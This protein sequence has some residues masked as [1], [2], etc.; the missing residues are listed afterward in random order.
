MTLTTLQP[1]SIQ[2]DRLHVSYLSAGS[3]ENPPLLLIHG[4]VSANLFWDDTLRALSEEYWVLAPD[5]RGYGQTEA[6]PIDA[7]RGLRDWSD[8][9]KLFLGA[10]GMSQPVHVLGWSLGAGIAMQLA[11]D[12][13]ATVRSLVLMSPLS[14]YGF[15][16]TKDDRG[17]PCYDNYAGS[18][19][20]TANP[21]FVACLSGK[22]RSVG[23]PN[24]PRN[25]LNQFYF[26]SPFRVGGEREE[27]Y[28]DAMLSTRIGDAH[29][30]GAF[31][32]CEHWPGVAPGAEGINNAMSPKYVNLSPIIHIE[33][34]RPILWIRGADDVIVSDSSWFDFGYLGK[35]G[36]VEGWPGEEV[37]PPQPMVSQM[38]CVLKQYEEAGG[39][40]EELVV[41]DAGHAPHIEQPE[42]VFAKLRSFLEIIE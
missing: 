14:P 2:T 11:I 36:Y 39:S 17:T 38:R 22:D 41:G 13:P 7:T 26:K 15:G 6:L 1:Q 3:A 35:L 5:L 33:P 20:G 42:I 29:Y 31:E 40:F 25:I 30:P 9:L 37:Y 27:R 28:L 8:D 32:T 16:G 18:G 19:G 21:Q 4:N 34:K 10:L 23:E 24:S 12:H